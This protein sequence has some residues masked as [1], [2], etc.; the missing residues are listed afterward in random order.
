MVETH[1]NLTYGSS[2]ADGKSHMF[3]NKLINSVPHNVW[4]SSMV[5]LLH[6]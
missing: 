4:C 1:A 3:G 2:T 6:S 5:A